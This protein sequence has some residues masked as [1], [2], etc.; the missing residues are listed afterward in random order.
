[1]TFPAYYRVGPNRYVE[2]FGLWFEDFAAGQR[3]R[4]RPGLTV[5][6]QDN[7]DE[8]LDTLNSAMLHFDEA[9][10]AH[11]TW[12]RPLVVSTLTVQRVLGM[13]SKT[14]A[15]RTALLGIDELRLGAPLLGGDTLYAESE[16]LDVHDGDRADAGIVVVQTVGLAASDTEVVRLRY[17]ISLPYREGN[18]CSRVGDPA[19]EPRFA[20]YELEGAVHV[21]RFG[22]FFEDCRPGECFVHA[23]RRTVLIEEAIAHA[24][25][26][27][28]YSARYH[29]VSAGGRFEV[30]PTFVLAVATTPATRTFARV[31][32][33]LG[34]QDVEFPEPVYAG[35]TLQA[36]SEILDARPSRSRP[37]EGLLHLATHAVN[38]HGETVL[39]YRRRLLVYR[40]DGATP[41]ASAGYAD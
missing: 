34:W 20:A 6:Q 4:H 28:D 19:D 39:S 1:V 29:D 32:A 5:S 31:V 16:I 15:L 8:A 3:F 40:R 17:R 30:P 18:D 25:R 13:T 22:L 23:P 41:F 38:Q 14:F 26:S 12:G 10:A 11:T 21:E 33:N 27:L 36:E 37:G 24:R 2:R 7:A 35:D 9:Y